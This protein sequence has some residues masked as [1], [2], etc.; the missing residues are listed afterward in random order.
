M[1]T[2]SLSI[3]AHAAG[4]AERYFE[5]GEWAAA[6]DAYAKRT[7]ADPDDVA[8]WFSLAVS[9]R[10]AER[11]SEAHDALTEAEKREFSPVRIGLERARLNVLAG[12]SDAAIAELQ[13]VAD[14]GFT[15][16]GVISGDPVLAKLAGQERYDALLAEMS[17]QAYPCEN[18]AAFR[19]FDFWLGDWDVHVANGTYAGSNRI[20][21]A[22]RGC[23]LTENWRSASGGTGSSINYV[24]GIT[25][26]WVQ[27][28]NDASGSQINIR[29]GMSEDGMRM[30]GTIHY[31]NNGTTAGFRG[32]WT[33]LPDGRVRQF[34]EQQSADGAT[35]AP[36]F[37]G[38]YSRKS[39]E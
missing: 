36:W 28:W 24:D 21:R 1:L 26:D 17:R 37:E 18:D 8:A 6:A 27:V 3:S 20:E 7:Q 11:Y 16:A 39:A 29:G 2:I 5:A 10:H 12:D 35:W 34:F 38:F 23:V 19:A 30:I 32:L 13:A 25:G 14:S 9:F 22:E 4:E 33:L 31:L 15:G